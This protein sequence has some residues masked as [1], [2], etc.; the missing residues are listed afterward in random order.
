MNARTK[1]LTSIALLVIF[2]ASFTFQ[3][4]AS[5]NSTDITLWINGQKLNLDV[6]PQVYNG[7]V[8]V[9]FRPILEAVGAKVTWDA[10]SQT[11]F[12]QKIPVV[13]AL[14]ANNKDAF[15]NGI[16]IRL[17]ES[18][19]FVNGRL[20]VPTRFVSEQLGSTVTWLTKEKKVVIS[21]S[22]DTSS[23]SSS[24]SG[25]GSSD[26]QLPPTAVSNTNS[27]KMG[28]L[29]DELIKTKG[30][31]KEIL[32]NQYGFYWYVYHNQYKNFELIGVDRDK[33][34]AKYNSSALTIKNFQISEGMTQSE[35]RKTF[36]PPI[37]TIRRGSVIYAYEDKAIDLFL[38]N[39]S[40]LRVFYDTIDQKAAR[41]FMIVEQ[42]VENNLKSYY[43]TSSNSIQQNFEYL[44]FLLTNQTRVSNDLKPLVWA[45][46]L[47]ESARL[48]SADM[49]ARGFFGHTN[50]DGKEPYQRLETTGI[51][52]SATAENLAAGQ[53]DPIHAHEALM[54]S[55]GHRRNIFTDML[56]LGVGIAYGGRYF[57]YYTCTYYTPQ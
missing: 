45:P 46:E 43:G 22:S 19:R 35:I 40:Y 6:P 33:V 28:T 36:G 31:P 47:L 24:S 55:P 38:V 27:V 14:K 53:F 29:I 23:S 39:G 41:S 42:S 54:N 56:K 44:M 37:T 51:S 34:V 25:S 26:N 18:V 3:S 17:D 21:T 30:Q 8:L 57:V 48:H 5:P 1:V 52:F 32:L 2:F 10:A 20:L 15:V 9:P 12:A 16:P 50:P 49:V 13:I 11:A 4:F 7:R